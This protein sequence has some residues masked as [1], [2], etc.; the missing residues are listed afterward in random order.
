M[1]WHYSKLTVAFL[2]VMLINMLVRTVP[3]EV[4]P[5]KIKSVPADNVLCVGMTIVSCIN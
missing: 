5:V 1:T 4:D 2:R 3:A